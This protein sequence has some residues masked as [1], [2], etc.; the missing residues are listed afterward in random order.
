VTILYNAIPPTATPLFRHR[1]Q[2]RPT[3]LGTRPN[4]PGWPETVRMLRV[5]LATAKTRAPQSGG[6]SADNVACAVIDRIDELGVRERHV[7][8][9]CLGILLRKSRH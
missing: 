1:R 4:V 7:L 3:G 8:A 2:Y 6:P 5:A 9:V